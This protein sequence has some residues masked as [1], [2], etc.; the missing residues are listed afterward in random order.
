MCITFAYKRGNWAAFTCGSSLVRLLKVR[1]A[2]N[3]R[4]KARGKQSHEKNTGGG[5][6]GKSART[7]SEKFKTAVQIFPSFTLSLSLSPSS[8][9]T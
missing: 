1:E 2:Q 5:K 4:K 7:K 3:H 6:T 8:L 9:P